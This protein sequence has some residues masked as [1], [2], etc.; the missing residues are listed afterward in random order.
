MEM[1]F[2]TSLLQNFTHAEFTINGKKANAELLLSCETSFIVHA[3]TF[4][5]NLHNC[6]WVPDKFHTIGQSWGK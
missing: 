5:W 1:T 6:S 4:S 3:M 2:D